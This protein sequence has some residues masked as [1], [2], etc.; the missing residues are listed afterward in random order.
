VPP[1]RELLSAIGLGRFDRE[2]A[3]SELI[4]QCPDVKKP[5]FVD[6]MAPPVSV[7]DSSKDLDV[8]D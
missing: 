7:T 2:P 5:N 1:R 3:R 6:F 8:P 4:A